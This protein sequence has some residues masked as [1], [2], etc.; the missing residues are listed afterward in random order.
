M[1]SPICRLKR[2]PKSCVCCWNPNSPA[3]GGKDKVRVDIRVLSATSKNIERE[4]AQGKFREELYH[5]LNVIPI[6][7]P[8]LEQR[9]DDI[10]ELAQHF[11]DVLHRQQGLPKRDLTEAAANA[12]QMLFWPGNLRQLRN[13]M[14]RILILGSDSRVID[15]KDLPIHGADHQDGSQGIKGNYA[16][17]IPTRGS[18]VVEREYLI[19]QVN[20]F[21]GN[22]SK[23]SNFVGMERSALHRKL[24]TLN[25][26]TDST[27]GA[28]YRTDWCEKR[29]EKKMRP[30]NAK[31]IT[32]ECHYE[33]SSF[34]GR[35]RLAGKSRIIW[36]RG[37]M[38][39][40]LSTIN[41]I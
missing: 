7:V 1:K 32:Q 9:C 20:R 12:L 3:S 37:V 17:F 5:R 29:C 15:E 36:R 8:S 33:E 25:V 2:N 27:D 16:I 31:K 19:V 30:K 21:G 41:P 39:S 14:E 38:R 24:K 40:R 13:M 4:I 22:I 6:H 26:I 28:A 18:R 11:I 23:T 10:P 35:V 34:V